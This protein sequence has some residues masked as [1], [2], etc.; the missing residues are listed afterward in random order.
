MSNAIQVRPVHSELRP[1]VTNS[2]LMLE[3]VTIKNFRCFKEAEAEKLGL[4]N[5]IVGDMA[6]GKSA[7]LEALFLLA[8]N[9]PAAHE[10]L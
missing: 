10:T 3:S 8:T 5:V 6:S 9:S 4:I 1:N 2:G 7:F